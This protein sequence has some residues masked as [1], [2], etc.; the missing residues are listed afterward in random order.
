MACD[1]LKQGFDMSCATIHRKY[2]QQAVLMNY[3]DLLTYYL[4]EYP[5]AYFRLRME[6]TGYM[7]KASN[8]SD[9][10]EGSYSRTKPKN[11]NLY[12]H[13]VSIPI[14]GVSSLP[15]NILKELDNGRFLAALKFNDGTIEIYGLEY[16]LEVSDYSY[17]AQNE[18]GGVVLQLESKNDEFL[19][20]LNYDVETGAA[21][22]F[23]D[24]FVNDG[25]PL[26]TKGDYNRDYSNDYTIDFI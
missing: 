26:P 24:L 21:S 5:I 10:I 14:V 9:N 15:K 23:E 8:I 1:T 20:P 7:F 6:K 22:D 25:S 3:R 17:S 4:Y 11:V 18:Q 2:A 16:G 12:R 19:P 13:I